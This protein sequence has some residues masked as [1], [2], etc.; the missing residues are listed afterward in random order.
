[1]SMTLEQGEALIAYVDASIT[2]LELHMHHLKA[3]S[4]LSARAVTAGEEQR[5]TALKNFK[6]L[7]P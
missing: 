4:D 7:L 6:D 5:E 3:P 2:S 1:M